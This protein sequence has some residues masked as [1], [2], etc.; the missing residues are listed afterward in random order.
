MSAEEFAAKTDRGNGTGGGGCARGIQP[1]L[2][3][4]K[5]TPAPRAPEDAPTPS[6]QP[7][8]PPK[9]APK[10]GDVDCSGFS[11]KVEAQP[12]LLPGD[13]NK[14]DKDGDGQR[15][16]TACPSACAAVCRRAMVA[17]SPTPPHLKAL[18][19][20][21]RE[22]IPGL[23]KVLREEPDPVLVVEMLGTIEVEGSEGS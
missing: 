13:P 23:M 3:Q 2:P 20:I 17:V 19:E 4:Q 10:R 1:E 18:E 12:F 6:P 8:P 5:Y 16:A 22:G 14:L 7:T 21:E 11:S 15:R 9:A